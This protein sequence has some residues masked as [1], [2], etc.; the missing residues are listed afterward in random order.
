MPEFRSALENG[1][2][3]LFHYQRY[4][5]DHLEN[6]LRR[7]LI[8]FSRASGFNDPWDCKPSFSVPDA[9]QEL[10]RLV[11]YMQNASKKHGSGMGPADARAREYL[12]DPG[13]L[14]ADFAAYSAEMWRQMDELYRVYC[15]SA[16]AN[17]QLL[18]GH[19]ADHHRGVCLE[20]DVQTEDI[21]S[22]TEVIYSATY[23]TFFLDD[24]TDLSPF[25]TKSSDWAYEEEYRLVAQEAD[26]AL[27]SGTLMTRDGMYQFPEGALVSVMVGSSAADAT[28]REIEDLARGTGIL[29]RTA[30]RV[31]HRYELT[32]D[33]PL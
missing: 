2:T 10:E 26:R 33:P 28:K 5:H 20:F 30:T 6:T 1:L 21:C 4:N 32:F 18:W 15:L 11:R 8:R 23:P 31:P 22:A 29:L 16:R 24:D 13:K 3:R 27:G 9:P 14:R 7:R 25:F 19:Y 12:A 17:S